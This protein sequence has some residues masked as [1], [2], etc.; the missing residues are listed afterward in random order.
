VN[1]LIGIT[2]TYAIFARTALQTPIRWE[3]TPSGFLYRLQKRADAAPP[4]AGAFA[5]T[6]IGPVN[7][8]RLR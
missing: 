6:A 2:Y 7:L 3:F 1:G 8:Y 4:A 5:M